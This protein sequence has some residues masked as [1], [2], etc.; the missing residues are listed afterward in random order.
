MS[1]A[2]GDGQLVGAGE[3]KERSECSLCLCVYIHVLLRD[4][5]CAIKHLHLCTPALGV[6]VVVSAYHL[7]YNNLCAKCLEKQG[8][9]VVEN[10]KAKQLGSNPAPTLGS[11]G[12]VAAHLTTLVS[13]SVAQARASWNYC[14]DERTLSVSLVWC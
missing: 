6:H 2:S 8:G 14:Q 4:N 12:M 7:C 1:A 13:A 5:M 11:C 3:T 9:L 10:L